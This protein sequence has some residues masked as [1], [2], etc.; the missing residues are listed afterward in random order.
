MVSKKEESNSFWDIA[1]TISEVIPK[2]LEKGGSP[3]FAPAWIVLIVSTVIPV[4]QNVVKFNFLSRWNLRYVLKRELVDRPK[5][6][7]KQMIQI[8]IH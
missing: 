4:H 3:S 8:Y 7:C 1:Q 5:I 2:F 6:F